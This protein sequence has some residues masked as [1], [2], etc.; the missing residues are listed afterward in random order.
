[1]V[2]ILLPSL[3]E[4]SYSKVS[5]WRKRKRGGKKAIIHVHVL[6]YTVNI[7]FQFFLG[8]LQATNSKGSSKRHGVQYLIDS[9][10]NLNRY[11]VSE[12]DTITVMCVHLPF[13]VPYTG[14]FSR[15]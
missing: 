2:D 9:L 8:T 7:F 14:K 3:S 15:R 5:E 12:C 10:Y 6:M 1:M 11:T 4:E 13:H